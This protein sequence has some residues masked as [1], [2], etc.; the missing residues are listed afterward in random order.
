MKNKNISLFAD[1]LY[2]QH[3]IHRDPS[4]EL[5]TVCLTAIQMALETKRPKF[6]AI[7]LNGMHVC[8]FIFKSK[9]KKTR[10]ETNFFKA[11]QHFVL[12]LGLSANLKC[13]SKKRWLRLKASKQ[14]RAFPK[15]ESEL[16]STNVDL[17]KMVS[18]FKSNIQI[19]DLGTISVKKSAES[20]CTCC[21]FSEISAEI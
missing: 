2:R 14:I 21:E 18:T 15:E 9:T 16:V 1:K 8:D 17:T 19:F 13:W 11:E 12:L 20:V 6:V 5:R 4:Y 3:G 7:A 10:L